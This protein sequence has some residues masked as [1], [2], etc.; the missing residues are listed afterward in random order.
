MKTAL[1]LSLSL[2]SQPSPFLTLP[3]SQLVHSKAS[4]RLQTQAWRATAATA[5]T[6]AATAATAA[7]TAAAFHVLRQNNI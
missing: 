2:S 1:A 6:A 3:L 4:R 5:A 7:A